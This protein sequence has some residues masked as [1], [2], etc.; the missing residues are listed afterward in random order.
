MVK[1][2]LFLGLGSGSFRLEQGSGGFLHFRHGTLFF[3]GCAVFAGLTG[4]FLAFIGSADQQIAAHE[5]LV[6][7]NVHGTDGAISF[8][9][10]LYFRILL[11]PVYQKTFL[12]SFL[13]QNRNQILLC[14]VDCN[15]SFPPFLLG[16]KGKSCALN[17]YTITISLYLFGTDS[18]VRL[19]S[20]ASSFGRS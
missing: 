20:T 18:S 1:W 19:I 16:M 5:R 3:P 12:S 2:L 9:F 14:P 6:V 4:L 15:T 10:L 13:T 11:P 8:V 7:E 17:A